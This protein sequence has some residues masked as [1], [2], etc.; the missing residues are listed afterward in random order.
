MKRDESFFALIAKD[1][2]K[3]GWFK[4]LPK[5]FTLILQNP[6]LHVVDVPKSPIPKNYF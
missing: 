1:K 6:L 4:T 5:G 2:K 3:L